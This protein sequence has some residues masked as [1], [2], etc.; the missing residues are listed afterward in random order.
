MT[1]AGVRVALVTG[2]NRGLGVETSR[3]LLAKGL[4]VALAGRDDQALARA[5]DELGVDA[6]RA[7][8]VRMDVT[9]VASITRA[10]R[11]VEGR[12]GGV[13]VL[14]NN[15]AVLE[16]ENEDALSIPAD[17]YRHTFETNVFAVIELCRVFA[18]MAEAR[19]GRIVK[20]SSDAGQ[21]CDHV[22]VRAGLLDV[23]DRPQRI[24]ADSGAHLS[25]QGR[26]GKRGRSRVGTHRHGRSVGA[27]LTSGRCRHHRLAGY[28][29]RRWPIRRVLPR[30]ARD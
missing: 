29:A 19:Y 9:D 27:A 28:A 23:E 5:V 7:M 16:F 14:V 17:A 20:V 26:A 6:D 11:L 18:P 4:R 13:D 21:L 10:H 12:F 8:T 15:A 2:A 1:P 30:S 3:Q 22:H 24:D 25:R